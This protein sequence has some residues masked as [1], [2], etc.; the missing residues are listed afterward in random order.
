MLGPAL[1]RVWETQGELC[2]RS[3]GVCVLGDENHAGKLAQAGQGELK[4]MKMKSFFFCFS[5]DCYC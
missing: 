2:S 1:Q 5:N 3:T 4:V